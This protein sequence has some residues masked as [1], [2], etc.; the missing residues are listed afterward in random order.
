MTPTLTQNSALR[1]AQS[2]T[3]PDFFPKDR[4]GRGKIPIALTSRD[5]AERYFVGRDFV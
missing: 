1:T 3:A 5:S 4:L 2:F